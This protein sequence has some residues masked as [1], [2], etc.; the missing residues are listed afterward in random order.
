MNTNKKQIIRLQVIIIS[1][2]ITACFVF[3]NESFAELKPM[4][5]TAMKTTHLNDFIRPLSRPIIV[6][7]Q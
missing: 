1:L 5:D 2:F 6:G 4:T 7:Q 3:P